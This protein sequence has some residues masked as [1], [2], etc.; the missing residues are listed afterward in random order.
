MPVHDWTRVPAGIFHDFH[1]EWIAAVKHKLNRVL[2]GSEY[3]A[4]A[5]QWAGGWGPDVVT[6]QRPEAPNVPPSG[7]H[8]STGTGR[9][10]PQPARGDDPRPGQKSGGIV[11]LEEPSREPTVLAIS[12]FPPR[13]R[14]HIVDERKWYLGKQKTVTVRHV[15]D[16]GVVAVFELLSP[17][18]KSSQGDLDDLVR[19]AR[20][21]LTA[22]IH[23]SLVDLFPP[24]RRDPQGIHPLIW[25]DDNQPF[26]FDPAKPLTCASYRAGPVPEAF[27]EPVGVGDALPELPIFLKGD[28]Y[29]PLVLEDA[30]QAAFAEV[31]AV[32]RD[33][34]V[35]MPA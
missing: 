21:L 29:V 25:G 26:P 4:L 34:L 9:R 30:Y 33:A 13:L 20:D 19:K 2:T 17:G 8:P 24:T 18:N 1:L 5:E 22:R 28:E 35:S 27:V 7:Q 11:A 3:Y 23:F 15:S 10:Q 32:W 14:F 6:L 16:H 12:D 31:P